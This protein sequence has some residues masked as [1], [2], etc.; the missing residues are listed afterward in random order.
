MPTL[1]LTR[2]PADLVAW[3]KAKAQAH[4]LSTSEMVWKI[5]E[6]ARDAE[7]ARRAGGVARQAGTTAAE[8]SAAGKRAVEAR[9]ARAREARGD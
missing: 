1:H 4:G 2:L 8:R 9:W 7:E 5:L 3:V 6:Q